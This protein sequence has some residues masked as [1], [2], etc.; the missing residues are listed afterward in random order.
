MDKRPFIRPIYL[1]L[2]YTRMTSMR[3]S[4][5]HRV[6]PPLVFLLLSLSS[7]GLTIWAQPGLAGADQVKL[8]VEKL[9]VVGSVLM[10][11]AHPDDDN[12]AVLAYYARGK[13]LKT[14][15]LS[16]TRGEGGQNLIGDEQGDKLG[17]I[18]TQELLDSRRIDGAQQFFT[19]VIDF[20]FTKTASETFE[21]WGH[22]KVL[23]DVVWVIRKFRPDVIILRFT[24]TPRDGH[25]QHQVSAIVGREAFAAAADPTE[26]P[27]Q[28]KYV[29][30]WQAK[31]LVWNAFAFTEQQQRELEKTGG[32]MDIDCGQY[33]PLLGYSFGE[34]AGMARSTNRTQGAGTPE[35]RGSLKQ[36]FTLVAGAPATKTPFEGIDTTWNRL[37]GGAAVGAILAQ[38]DRELEPEHPEKIIPLLLK[39]R[40]LMEA[41]H[42]PYAKEKL[43]ELDNTIALCA[44]LWLDVS[45]DHADIVPGTSARLN[46]TAIN[47]SPVP[48]TLESIGWTGTAVSRPEVVPV[49]A[50]LADN[51]PVTR[52]VEWKTAEDQPYTQPYW[53]REPP[54]GDD[55][56]IPDQR[57][58]GLP[59]NPPLLTA[60]FVL[61]V[62]GTE[63][64]L[65]RVVDHRYVDHVRGEIVTPLAIVP[66]VALDVSEDAMIFPNRAPK[67]YEVPVR[68]NAPSQSGV[69]R[70]SAPEGWAVQPAS[71]PFDLHDVGEQVVAAFEV[72][73][74]AAGSVGHLKAVAQDGG[75]EIASAMDVISYP[76]IPPQTLFPT[77]QTRVV[78]AD[79]RTLAHRIGYI[80]GPGDKMPPALEQ[81]GC[82][83]TLL[84]SA[85]L[86][87]GD[88]AQYDAIV[89]GVRAF[90]TRADLRAN[91]QRLL[92]YV[93]SGG[94]LVVQYNVATYGADQGV[95]ARI[96]P[97]PIHVS[98]ERVTVEQAPVSFPTPDSPLLQEP[99]RITEKDF[100]GW[101]QERGLYFAD[102]Y[103][104]RYQS[105][106]ASHDPGEA[107]LKGGTLFTQY[108]KGAYI[109]T[110][111]SWFRQLPAGVPG[112]FRIFANFLSAGKVLAAR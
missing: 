85:D 23:S 104:S 55:Y 91:M 79:I 99:N 63:I 77:S 31:R 9:N 40:P 101:V 5:F 64:A 3:N 12:T 35:R 74:P 76:H 102:K 48:M 21:K 87:Q 50:D 24:G 25:G 65:D 38:A 1:I 14:A 93:K 112:A 29:K 78:H 58:V 94:T 7:G 57:L 19:R 68:A 27:E 100:D 30:P 34:I 33:D 69:V 13:K 86:A 98:H 110:A 49:N 16:L 54:E 88:L 36:F 71:E 45:S 83:V 53:L 44:G 15:Y 103:D 75:R 52:T 61:E 108:G 42:D 92:D 18:R 6:F 105:L 73:P 20:G 62:D 90:N 70:V 11:A 56:R 72:T 43:E 67:R 84:D 17:V 81:M 4:K 80:M 97:Y 96:G 106:L 109:F 37:P 89:T 66:P 32:K 10:I 46:I 82:N 111:Y 107:E 8:A 2:D 95:L 59:Q 47:R 22:E 26:F 39:A 28:L 60:R 41:I 51:Q